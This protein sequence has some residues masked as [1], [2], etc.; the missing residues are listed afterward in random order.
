MRRAPAINPLWL[1]I[2][3]EAETPHKGTRD[4]PRHTGSP[5]RLGLLGGQRPPLGDPESITL[6]ELLFGANEL[7]YIPNHKCYRARLVEKEESHCR[8]LEISRVSKSENPVVQEL[9]RRI[10]CRQKGI[11]ESRPTC[12]VTQLK[13]YG[14]GG[15]KDALDDER[16]VAMIQCPWFVNVSKAAEDLAL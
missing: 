14:I 6:G 10:P 9:G 5:R 11:G 12:V 15:W 8:L 13:G 3:H 16:V 7:L 4:G 1:E 2:V